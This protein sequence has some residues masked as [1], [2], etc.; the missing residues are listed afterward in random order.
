MPENC[1]EA[2]A[3]VMVLEHCDD[4][5]LFFYPGLKDLE[6][7]GIIVNLFYMK[8]KSLFKHVSIKCNSTKLPKIALISLVP[9]DNTT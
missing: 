2:V 3:E 9:N 1:K 4:K 6:M 7:I 5:D 8:I